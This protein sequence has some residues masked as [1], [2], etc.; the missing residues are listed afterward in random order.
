MF[1]DANWETLDLSAA[2]TTLAAGD[3]PGSVKVFEMISRSDVL[4][5]KVF[6]G[7]DGFDYEP[8]ALMAAVAAKPGSAYVSRVSEGVRSLHQ[9]R[10][11]LPLRLSPMPA[12]AHAIRRPSARLRIARWNG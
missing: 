8:P 12:L 4:W 1:E 5:A 7:L 10:W 11:P 3:Y 2:D 6:F 9:L